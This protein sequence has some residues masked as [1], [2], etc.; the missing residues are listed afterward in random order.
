MNL[1]I[2]ARVDQDMILRSL[3][4]CVAVLVS[5]S[6][7]FCQ[8]SHRC[9]DDG[10][11]L[12]LVHSDPAAFYSSVDM[13]PRGNLNVG[14]RDA[15]YLFEADGN[16]GLYFNVTDRQQAGGSVIEAQ[17]R[18]SAHEKQLDSH[19]VNGGILPKVAPR[20][21]A[22]RP[23]GEWNK[24][25]VTS[26][27]GNVTFRLNGVT[28]N[29]VKLS[30]PRLESMPEQDYIGFQDRGLPFWLRNVKIRSREPSPTS[31]PSAVSDGPEISD[32][33]ETLTVL[34]DIVPV[35]FD[36]LV[37]ADGEESSTV[38]KVRPKPAKKGALERPAAAKRGAERKDAAVANSRV[39]QA[40]AVPNILWITVED[41]SPTLGCYGDSFARTPNIDALARESVLYTN[42]FAASPVCSPSRSTLITGMYNASMG[43]NQMRSSNHIPTG[44][45]GFPSL[46]RKAG[47]YTSNNVKTDYNCAENERLIK[48]SWND[49]SANA[50]WK[51]RKS[52][53]PFFSVFNDM[54]TH[55][56]RTMVW[57][58]P[59][60]QQHIQSRLSTQ[61]ISNPAVV[62]LPPYY[63]DTP[64]I[65]KTMARFYDCVSVMDQNVKRILDQLEADGLAD[66]TIVFFYSDHGSGMPRHKR[67][68]L[69]SGMRVALMVR[70]PEKYKHLAPAAPGSRL[71]RVVSFVDFPATVLNLTGQAVP[72]Y[73]QGIPFLG[74]DSE[75]ERET[76][77]GTRDRVD[78]VQEMARSVRDKQFLY[79]RNYMPHLSYNQPSVFSD[80]SEI[81]KDISRAA[82]SNLAS[83]TGPQRAYAG[84]RKPV[85]EFYDCIADPHNIVNLIPGELNPV[86]QAALQRLRAAYA[87]TR[88]EI[89][90]VGALPESVM[91]DQVREEGAP[92]RDIMRGKTNH[93][94][95]LKAAWAAADVVGTKNRDAL[96]TH[97]RS[98][99]A[100]DRYWAL[101]GMRVDFAEDAA[102]H[103]LAA[104]H[105]TDVSADVRIE[106]ASWLAESSTQY[107]DRALQ[108]LIADTSLDDW[109]SALR[110]CRAIELL[111][112]KA[113]SLLPE[114]KELY[115]KHR[116][117]PGDQSFFLAF[118][119]GAFLEQFGAKTTPWDFSPG[120]GGFSAD[121]DKKK[122]SAAGDE[123]GFT[124][125]F[126]GKS[127]DQWDHR[128]DAWEVAGGAISCTGKEKTRNWIIWR[129]GTPS[130]FVLRLDFK[131]EAGNSGVQVRSDVQG[132]HQV[133]GYQVEIAP[134][135][136]MGLWHHS[137]LGKEDPTHA[138]RFFMAT[139]GQ[140]VAITTDGEKSVTQI[141]AAEEIVAHY[142]QDD[143]NSME[144]VA[145]GNTL[146][147]KINGVVFSQVTDDDKRMSRSEG[148]IALQDHGKG[149]QV[150]FKNV[151]IK[152]LSHEK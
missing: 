38:N 129:G 100:A 112:P 146:I 2:R 66:D 35:S 62:P 22:S 83:L 65:R 144:I 34:R 17:I 82:K 8:D 75:T 132:D 55:Q 61:Q 103:H 127:L 133:F 47:Y 41:M 108:S 91:R 19:A 86:Q 92:I 31:D 46:L 121:P 141:A 60:F 68:L 6:V 18:D 140:K 149:C 13:D 29:N 4:V 48:E 9:V 136:K 96:V 44:V 142:Q 64:V 85:E 117:Q 115:A 124:P 119:S 72:D 45:K 27:S 81:R 104:N 98:F 147:Q 76:V 21:S 89:Q 5:C 51:D 37:S 52:D 125:I 145:D 126:D 90:D 151:R 138:A 88:T 25:S 20:A 28:V 130:D 16:D 150:A 40:G 80:L 95:D 111:G 87:R 78:E 107:R 50:H 23:A 54:T 106:A 67:L 53:Q 74:P 3:F 39:G 99:S 71:D 36:I 139:A 7:A 143:W 118:S 135:K 97:L 11:R 56:S 148:V 131:Y 137:L 10:L 113:E 105:L 79:I 114:I 84:P 24:M 77:Y 128:K 134:Q 43:T 49:S 123:T 33:P 30:H 42:A 63:P 32:N 1:R 102:L 58:Y 70:F 152:E 101:V 94:P 116:N 110:A 26:V 73:M 93:A 15:V 57:P 120:A 59:V 122:S 109:W 12:D 69:D 14:G